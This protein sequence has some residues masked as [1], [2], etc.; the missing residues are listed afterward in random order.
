MLKSLAFLLCA[1]LVSAA[2]TCRREVAVSPTSTCGVQQT[3]YNEGECLCCYYNTKN[4]P[5]IGIGYSL[6]L[7]N[8]AQVLSKYNLTLADVLQDCT[9][10]T[11]KH[12]LTPAQAEDIFKTVSYPE[13]E[14]CA[15]SYFPGLPP[16]V[17]AA[18]VDIAVTDCGALNGLVKMNAALQRRDWKMVA[19]ELRSSAW[20]R[21]SGPTRCNS[22]SMCI[23]SANRMSRIFLF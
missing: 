6:D 3:I 4:I 20:C 10:K 19:T 7:P 8:S 17:R 13:A 9:D 23:E 2:D 18:I 5:T 15:D 12:C 16:A 11:T 14:Q 1:Y 21:Q 22:N